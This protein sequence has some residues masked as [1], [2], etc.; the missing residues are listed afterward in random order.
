MTQGRFIYRVN[1]VVIAT[2]VPLTFIAVTPW[3]N[4]DGTNQIK[5]L[6]L[7]AFGSIAF[8]LTLFSLV[9][10]IALR[11]ID[12]FNFLALTSIFLV[13]VSLL[14][15]RNSLDERL[16]GIYGRSLGAITFI[17]LFFIMIA[18]SLFSRDKLN[19]LNINVLLSLFAVASYFAIQRAGLDPASWEDPYGAIP[20]STLGNPN[21]VSSSL[22]ILS[23]PI[24]VLLFY[25]TRLI[26]L[27]RLGFVPLIAII[28][29][30]ILETE[31][32]QG[33]LIIV[34][35]FIFVLLMRIND[36]LSNRFNGL[37]KAIT[38]A[39]IVAI[40]LATLLV[41]LGYSPQIGGATVIART[42]YWRAS[43]TLLL[44]NPLFGKGFDTFGDWYFFYRDQLAVDRS[45]GLFSDS[46]HNLFLEMG[47]FGGFPLLICY[48][49]LQGIVLQSAL[50]IVSQNGNLQLK[51]LVVAW[52]GFTLQSAI[53]PSS[54][55]LMT[56]GF[57]LMG[58]IYGAGK[59][60][61]G[62]ESSKAKGEYKKSRELT[63]EVTG[64]LVLSS[65]ALSIAGA[66]IYLGFAPIAKD[67]RFR[68]AIEQGNGGRM[69]EVSRQWPFVYQISRLTAM[70]LKENSFDDLAIEIVRELIDRNPNNIQGWRML[71]DYSTTTAERATALAKMRELDP[72]NPELAK[73]T[74]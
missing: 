55:A 8:A 43:W 53:S 41:A 28:G 4:L 18:A 48:L 73:F 34:F 57:V 14:V 60:I 54:L 49:L 67:A 63:I 71:F 5:F 33:F 68:D 42:D 38:T 72:L 35:M 12:S 37:I 10:R 66:G 64:R 56:L 32:I 19:F 36:L 30:L 26:H 45:P 46:A 20:S 9:K 2:L 16:F 44:E 17:S 40:P 65:F 21:Y 74:P 1:D 3:N 62:K 13:L 23:A 29:F 25:K 59:D 31:S 47:V 27:I 61:T 24:F 70:T 50:R 51:A 15:N 58:I 69:I 6:F 7:V 22:A 11:G 52:I 39:V